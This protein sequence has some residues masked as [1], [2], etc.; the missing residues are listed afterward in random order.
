MDN[1]SFPA[2]RDCVPGREI[3]DEFD[4]SI[5]IY[6]NAPSPP[7]TFPTWEIAVKI[8]FYV[9]AMLLDVVGNSI[10]IL[11]IVLN[12]KMRTTTNV[13][14]LNLAV[15]D[16]MVAAFCMWVHVGYQIAPEWPF[17]DF[18]CKGNTFFQGRSYVMEDGLA[19]RVSVCQRITV[20]DSY[21]AEKFRV[22]G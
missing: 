9:F 15:S 5:L 18:V 4:P 12:R 21:C 16:L 6:I 14:I 8:L 22:F 11:I 17:G 10:V 19:L 20:C 1:Y 7:P 2:S 13:L 3:E